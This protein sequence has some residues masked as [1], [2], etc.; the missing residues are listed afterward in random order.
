MFHPYFFRQ[1]KPVKFSPLYRL[2][3]MIAQNKTTSYIEIIVLILLFM[4]PVFSFGEV[5]Q[6]FW[7]S[8]AYSQ[9]K[10]LTPV[11]IKV[12]KDLLVII[13]FLLIARN[14]LISQKLNTYMAMCAPLV[15]IIVTP[16]FACHYYN[17]HLSQSR[18]LDG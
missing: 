3:M 1:E 16:I 9:S 7:K 12:L 4:T 10:I 13:L 5:I 15:F 11:Y 6:L 8:G 17:N 18:E 14:I 2:V